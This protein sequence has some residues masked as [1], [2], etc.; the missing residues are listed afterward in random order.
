MRIFKI[1]TFVPIK[2]A[3]KVRQAMGDAGAGTWRNY[4]HTSFSS[5]GVGRFTPAKGAQPAIGEVG[6]SEEVEEERIEVICEKEKVKDVMAAIEKV[7]PYEEIPLEIY[8]LLD[9]E[10]LE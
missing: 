5:R 6:K 8:Q 1:V 9:E 3:Q 7:H 2:D 10:E 4:H